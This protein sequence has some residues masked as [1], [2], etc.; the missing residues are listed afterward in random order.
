MIDA[1]IIKG[2]VF[3]SL[4]AAASWSDVKTRQVSD[5]YSIL[6][7][8][9]ALSTS[10]YVNWW[11]IF[12]GMPFLAAAVRSGGIGGADIKIMSA[13]GMV[14]GFFP[15]ITAMIMGLIGMLLFHLIERVIHRKELLN[16]AYP[17]IPFLTAGILI[18]YMKQMF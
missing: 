5:Y 4:L 2:V 6:L 11:G 12:C 1:K 18:V 14:I 3:L 8:L 15:G 13:A 9:F 7:V 10:P 17:L 16:Q